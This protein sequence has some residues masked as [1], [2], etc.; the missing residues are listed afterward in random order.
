MG[1]NTE[2]HA[3]KL[4]DN[5]LNRSG[6]L[7]AG[8]NNSWKGKPAEGLEDGILTAYEASNVVL[9]NTKL[10]TL[11][12]CET[13]LGDI[14]GSEGVYGLQ[15]AFKMA[16]AEYLLMSLWK[17]PDAETAEF[18]EHFY[19]KWFSGGTIEAAF[20]ETQHYMKRRYPGTPYKWAAFVLIR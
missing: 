3:F 13:G 10:V 1:Q 4:S 15:R 12:A 8:A 17:V 19:G 18:M 7:F 14:K 20:Q 16:G 6:L 11:S 5:P 9:T 2:Q